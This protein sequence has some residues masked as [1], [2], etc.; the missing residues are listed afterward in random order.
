MNVFVFPGQGSQERGMGRD[1]F[2][3]VVE[4]SV[5]EA[6]I[7]T[8]LGYSLRQ[9]CLEDPQQLLKQTQYTQPALYVVNGLA[10]LKKIA[11]TG[12]KPDYV[13]GHSLGEYNALWAAGAFDFLTG[14]RLVQERGRLMA[15]AKNG[16]MAAVIGLFPPQIAEALQKNGLAGIDIA[17]YNAPSQTV[18]SGPVT[19]ISQAEAVLGEAGARLCLPLPVSAAFHSRYMAQASE[20]FADFLA[21][22][23]FKTLAI[24][25]I[26]NVT[27]RPYPTDNP[28]QTIKSLLVKQITHPV[29]WT[30]SIRY[31]SGK[32]A[33]TFSEIGPGK[34]LTGLVQRIQREAS[35]LVEEDRP[36][37][38]EAV[39]PKPIGTNGKVK[40]SYAMDRPEV[41]EITPE[42]LGSAA[43]KADYGLKYAYVAGA[44]YK[45]IA[46]KE[47]VVAMGRAGL[48]GYLGTGGMSLAEI[49]A[50]IQYIQAA[51]SQTQAYGMNLLANL[52]QP[53]LEEQTVELFLR[54]G[55]RYIEAA[56]YMQ[57]TPSLVRFRLKGIHR[58]PAG[59]IV[60]PHHVLAKVSRPEVATAF[61][62]P[63]PSRIVQKLVAAGHLTE[64]EADLGRL[65]PM[66]EDICVEADSAGHTD[67]G[68]AYALMPAMLS[69]RDEMMAQYNYPKPI[70]VGAAGGIGAPEAAAAAFILGA[71][72][73]LTG[74]IN[75]CTVEA[76]TSPV[77]KDMLQDINVQDTAYA[78]AGDM[79][80]L[81][82]KVQVLRR[83]VFFPARA[84][85]L[86]A[87]YQQHNSLDE[88]DPKT[89]H[90]IQEKYF[91]RS[92]DEVWTETRA[93][94][95]K[96]QPEEIE[97]AEQNPKHK[98]ALIFRWYF[99]HTT[100]LALQGGDEQRVDYQVHCGPAL[101]AF[102][103]WV[104][105]TALADWRNRHV[106]DIAERLMRGTAA[107]LNKRFAALSR[108]DRGE[109][110]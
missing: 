102:N 1:L 60:V 109:H 41:G 76:G 54:C 84:N 14:L 38:G 55:I 61:M 5:F 106:A 64:T 17:N 75:Q 50:E 79:F 85:K 98:M 24:P 22:F 27:G 82:A 7:E 36:A 43:F 96:T 97:R 103:Q 67:Q 48:I 26:S 13:A 19:D 101:G 28:T 37:Q 35:P 66:S 99:V 65:V 92:F 71:D 6:E 8:L 51:L 23:E 52:S 21:P 107:L 20:Q 45:G 80:E 56:A 32:G 10:Y 46:S 31:L 81:G 33:K 88:I 104:K 89:Q 40:A 77:V 62:Q 74:S 49:E 87:L 90:Q 2:D 94:Y 110:A 42:S 9:L 95:L 93:H 4:F 91:K 15:Q 68:V 100:R 58:T 78:P 63:A 44:M 16:G 18:I 72:F 86:Y 83:G 57:M 34:V 3:A 59:A 73:I 47:L 29:Q 11:E 70:R 53:Q 108:R 105:G 12:Q 25:V 39:T 30:D 69:L